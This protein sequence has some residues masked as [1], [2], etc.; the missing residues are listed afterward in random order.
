MTP[1][2]I[3]LEYQTRHHG[4]HST[5]AREGDDMRGSLTLGQERLIITLGPKAF[6]LPT[7]AEPGPGG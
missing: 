2:A 1:L 5:V 4:H 6:G 3:K 7:G